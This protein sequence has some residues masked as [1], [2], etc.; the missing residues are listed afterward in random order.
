LRD[1]DIAGIIR[2][3]SVLPREEGLELLHAI[4]KQVLSSTEDSFTRELKLFERVAASLA[5][6]SVVALEVIKAQ[7]KENSREREWNQLL[8]QV[9]RSLFGHGV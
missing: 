9:A 1:S 5:L 8:D 7:L 6:D 3:L 2:S 4:A